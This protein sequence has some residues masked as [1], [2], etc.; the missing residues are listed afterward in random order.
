LYPTLLTKAFIVTTA[1]DLH[2]KQ[3]SNLKVSV[4]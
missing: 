1:H 3:K 2:P 4:A